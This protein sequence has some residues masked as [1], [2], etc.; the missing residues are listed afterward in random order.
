MGDQAVEAVLCWFLQARCDTHNM[1]HTF[2]EPFALV[3][4]KLKPLHVIPGVG[5]LDVPTIAMIT[6]HTMDFMQASADTTLP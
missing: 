6:A 3:L 4:R 2:G 1:L 5:Q